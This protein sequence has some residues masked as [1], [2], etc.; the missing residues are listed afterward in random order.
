MFRFRFL[1]L[2]VFFLVLTLG[3]GFAKKKAEIEV[4]EDPLV[5]ARAVLER[6]ANGQPM[7]SEVTSFPKMVEDVRAV[8]AA[9]A[10]ILEKGLEDL[11]KASASARAAKAKELLSQLK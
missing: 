1:T 3:C 9:K 8:D 6:Y 2:G 5:N 11:K 4:K 7:T 10:S